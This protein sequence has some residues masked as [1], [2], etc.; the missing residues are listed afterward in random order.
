[1]RPAV[2]QPEGVAVAQQVARVPAAMQREQRAE[3]QEPG[4]VAGREQRAELVRV[5]LALPQ[6]AAGVRPELVRPLAELVL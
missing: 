3:W 1:M 4:T 2:V 5:L 6:V